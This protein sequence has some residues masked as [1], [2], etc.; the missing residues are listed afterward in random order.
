LAIQDVGVV[1]NNAKLRVTDGVRTVEKEIVVRAEYQ[2]EVA[3]SDIS[4]DFTQYN[5]IEGYD[6][7]FQGGYCEIGIEFFVHKNGTIY[8]MWTPSGGPYQFDF[9]QDWNVNAPNVT[10]PENFEVRLDIVSGDT[11]FG[12]IGIWENMNAFFNGSFESWLFAAQAEF[13]SPIYP[14]VDTVVGT[15]LLQIREVG[16]PNSVKQKT[17]DIKL[18]AVSVP[19]GV[20]PP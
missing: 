7:T 9:P 1:E 18:T 16:R 19:P 2:E 14:R 20:I 5:K 11:P 15:Y 13:D 10:D 6:E 12:P 8:V 17:F 4:D 3:E